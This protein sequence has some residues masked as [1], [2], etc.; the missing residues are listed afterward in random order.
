[1]RIANPAFD[2]N[3][4]SRENIFY[5]FDDNDKVIGKALLTI[6]LN[7]K[8]STSYPLNIYFVIN[9][10]GNT[11]S[12]LFGAVMARAYQA[13]KFSFPQYN[14]RIYTKV[15]PE[16]IESLQFYTYTGLANND[17]D[18]IIQIN[19][20][21]DVKY[22]LA[23]YGFSI[24]EIPSNSES[25][26]TMIA[27]RYNEYLLHPITLD[28]LKKCKASEHFLAV[29]IVL[30]NYCVGEALFYGN[31]NMATMLGI[32]VDPAYREKG[33]AREL[34]RS[35]MHKLREQGVTHFYTTL[36][37]RSIAQRKLAVH[38]RYK[39]I[40]TIS[41]YPGICVNGSFAIPTSSLTHQELQN[42]YY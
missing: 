10:E 5:A 30:N 42:G 16:D 14:A 1:M 27:N 33:I 3:G 23:Y 9:A 17:R 22:N 29:G 41:L 8:F 13:C 31:N 18:E 26:L 19:M 4:I 2:E 39:A 12:K 15:D 40:K 28:T 38:C 7:L 11:R 25:E 20:P 32:Y 35:S 24:Q 21:L 36:Q 37:R 6:S 34:I